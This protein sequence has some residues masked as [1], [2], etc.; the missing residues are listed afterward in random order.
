MRF[1]QMRDVVVEFSIRPRVT[2]RTNPHGMKLR[3]V[4]ALKQ[5]VFDERK[6]SRR[7]TDDL[8][9]LAV[10]G[11]D[12]FHARANIYLRE[13]LQGSTFVRLWC[14]PYHLFWCHPLSGNLR[15]WC[16]P[17]ACLTDFLCDLLT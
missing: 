15:L 14:H 8:Y 6:S 1:E 12:V 13:Y 11:E 10:V 5:A 2:E 7:A 3:F 9:C 17:S 4:P 16:H